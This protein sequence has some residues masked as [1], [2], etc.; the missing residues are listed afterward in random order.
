MCVKTSVKVVCHAL[1]LFVKNNRLVFTFP[2]SVIEKSATTVSDS[3][4]SGLTV[5]LETV[6]TVCGFLVFLPNSDIIFSF[7]NT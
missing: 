4:L 1:G 6:E 2:P 5:F 7:L 3:S